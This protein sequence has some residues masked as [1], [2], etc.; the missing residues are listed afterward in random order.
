MFV[1]VVAVPALLV[2]LVG[3]VVGYGLCSWIGGLVD[4]STGTSLASGA[5]LVG[6]IT[7]C[8]LLIGSATV[9]VVRR[10]RVRRRRGRPD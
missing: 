2:V 9:V 7:G 10:R 1:F 5:E 8:L 4:A 3:Y 6:W